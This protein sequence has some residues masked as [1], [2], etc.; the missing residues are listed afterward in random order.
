MQE[1]QRQLQQ[2]YA[3]LTSIKDFYAHIMSSMREGVVWLNENGWLVF[4]NHGFATIA[5]RP[6]NG[7]LH[8]PF[9]NLLEKNDMAR[10]TT[11]M[12]LCK[13]NP[14]ADKNAE[15]MII[16]PSGEK[17]VASINLKWVEGT[18]SQRGFLCTIRDISEKRKI[19]QDLYLSRNRY[20]SLYENSPALIVGLD[21]SG[22]LVFANP[23]MV[24]QS[25]YSEDELTSMHFKQL[26]APDAD[27]DVMSFLNARL[28]A[29]HLQ[30]ARFRTKS[31]EWKTITL[32]TYP[33]LDENGMTAGLGA[34]GIDVTE[35]KRLNE[36]LIQTQ[37]M[38]LLGKMAGG[39]VH[40]FGNILHSIQGYSK[41]ITLRSSEEQIRKYA[42][43]IQKSGERATQLTRN[44]LTFSRGE[45]VNCR[46]FN[47]NEL[48]GEVAS[49]LEPIVPSS[50]AIKIVV[51]EHDIFITADSGK[52]HQCLLNL[53]LNARDAIGMKPGA[54]TLSVSQ[55][56]SNIV[57]I[58]L[59][60]SGT[61]IPPDLI[62]KI[63]DPFFSTKSKGKGT[64]SGYL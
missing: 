41:L 6:E 27:F 46:E 30:E 39:L 42:Q 60:D 48:I 62:E 50:I 56:E 40:D 52:I 47:L 28:T 58:E 21:S 44:L 24:Q 4:L 1:S 7:L 29:D 61:G 11:L 8:S 5:D 49:L 38:D 36:Q 34:I 12:Q 23:A 16:R 9:L 13:D 37:R 10:F 19:E 54:I 26:L 53:G 20:R 14:L 17:R 33:L 43:M 3:E 22:M 57:R 15:F 25:G 59:E 35:T 2:Q 51:P 63:F 55:P 64:A 31:G 18:L 32:S 45:V